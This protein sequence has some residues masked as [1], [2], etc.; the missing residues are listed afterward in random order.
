[1]LKKK[2]TL[3]SIISIIILSL[4]VSFVI[5]ERYHY[6]EKVIGTN[7]G[8]LTAGDGA[9]GTKLVIPAGALSE[10]TLISMEVTSDELEHIDFVFGPHGTVFNSPVELELSWAT[11]NG[12]T[13]S[14]LV[15]YHW[16]ES[17]QQW[18]EET[19]AVWDD[20]NKKAT[21]YID[22]FSKYYY[23]RP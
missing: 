1:M 3:A 17:S 21:L 23:D 6:K 20:N 4:V 19:T 14:D 7:G 5:A 11:I 10:D 16:H 13:S 9:P 2:A 8:K 15:L 22:H 12:A 18:V